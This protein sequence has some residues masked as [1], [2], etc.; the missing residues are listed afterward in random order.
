MKKNWL[1]VAAFLLFLGIRVNALEAVPKP[2]AIHLE[3]ASGTIVHVG[4]NEALL[5][6]RLNLTDEE[7]TKSYDEW[8]WPD[9]INEVFRLS[10]IGTE[11]KVGDKIR[12]KYA[13]MTNS[14][15]PLVPVQSYE[16]LSPQS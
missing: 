2:P 13:I 16:L 10:N 4:E 7:L 9:T 6:K 14:I 15:P 5:V 8:L 3:Q 11:L 12:F 1:V